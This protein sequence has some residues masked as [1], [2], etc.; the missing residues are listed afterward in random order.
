MVK[1][2]TR[3]YWVGLFAALIL[4][5]LQ[6]TAMARDNSKYHPS[7]RVKESLQTP[8]PEKSFPQT[9]SGETKEN[10]KMSLISGIQQGDLQSS[11]FFQGLDLR[12]EPVSIC[13]SS[14][15]NSVDLETRLNGCPQLRDEIIWETGSGER[16]P[17]PEWTREQKSR[18]EYFFQALLRGDANLGI[19]CPDLT[20]GSNHDAYKLF[21]SADQAFDIYAAHVAHALYLEVTGSVPWSL[22]DLPPEEKAVILASYHYQA[23]ILPSM[24]TQHQDIYM[25][26]QPN[27]DFQSLPR[28]YSAESLI[29]DPRV[30]YRFLRGE[31]STLHQNLVGRN[32]EETLQNI[33]WWYYNNVSHGSGIASYDDQWARHYAMLQDRLRRQ[34]V[35]GGSGIFIGSV[36]APGGCHSAANL[37]LDLARSVNIPLLV[38]TTFDE[39]PTV[40]REIP[41][42]V[43]G[44]AASH[45]GLVFRWA[46]SHPLVLQHM[47]DIYTS[48]RPFFLVREDGSRA[49]DEAPRQFF[50]TNWLSP[51]TL[52]SWGFNYLTDL[53]LVHPGSGYGIYTSPMIGYS[54]LGYIGGFWLPATP[55]SGVDTGR[56]DRLRNNF[57]YEKGYHLCSW[58]NFIEL[59]CNARD[60][61]H[62][63]F[64]GELISREI[65]LRG[66]TFRLPISHTSDDFL[67]RA[68]ECVA[69][70]GGCDS[71]RFAYQNWL[72]N[73]GSNTLP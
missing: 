44:G 72:R 12:D 18:L 53:P 33:T 65:T 64:Q 43:G 37:M 36:V 25:I 17:Y 21:L 52:I 7:E 59:Y 19:H 30:G 27:R 40:T 23:R 46:R 32:E 10:S 20:T 8:S 41:Y 48:L 1:D 29:C 11:F 51:E 5:C 2:Q 9:T 45:N 73:L 66:A 54:D 6:P 16:H 61:E 50:E 3:R 42:Q 31:T 63:F 58:S 24:W 67:H 62:L 49:V 34:R 55:P 4:L 39:A 14:L 15:R 70:Y 26:F 69:S 22:M 47:D 35:P 60:P 56:D 28:E 68:E 71:I 38:I 13:R 57:I